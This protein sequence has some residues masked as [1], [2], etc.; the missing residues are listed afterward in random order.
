VNDVL[1]KPIVAFEDY[2]DFDYDDLTD[3]YQYIDEEENIKAKKW[4]RGVQKRIYFRV[5]RHDDS[6]KFR[7]FYVEMPIEGE[8]QQ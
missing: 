1:K 3:S 8:N 6:R 7:E 4:D 2:P 5:R